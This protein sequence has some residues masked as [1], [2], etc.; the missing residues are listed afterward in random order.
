MTGIDTEKTAHDVHMPE[1]IWIL[2]KI[3]SESAFHCEKC[4]SRAVKYIRADAVNE[5]D[6]QRAAVDAAAWI[7]AG[8]GK[9]RE[10]R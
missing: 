10:C 7:I 6:S 5:M 1:L 3:A 4:G 8:A 2:P 9:E